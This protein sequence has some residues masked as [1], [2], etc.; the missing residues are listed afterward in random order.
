MTDIKYV[1][2]EIARPGSTYPQ[3]LSEEAW[4]IEEKGK[5]TLTSRAG[6]PLRG[7]QNK[8]YSQK[9]NGEDPRRIAKRLLKDFH[10]AKRGNK[11][12][13]NRTISYPKQGIA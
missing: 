11:S 6:V 2:T 10:Y 4:Y 5:V 7:A 1:V 8:I 12:D 9:L 13:F 3:G